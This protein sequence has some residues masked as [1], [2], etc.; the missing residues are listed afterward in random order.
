M[1]NLGNVQRGTRLLDLPD[2]I[3]IQIAK[4]SAPPDIY[5]LC[6]TSKHFHSATVGE[7]RKRQGDGK[8]SLASHLMHV[9]MKCNLTTVLAKNTGPGSFV[10]D[11]LSQFEPSSMILTGSTVACAALGGTF[12]C[13]DTDIFKTPGAAPAVRSM[14]VKEG[15]YVL[16][17][18]QYNYYYDS[19]SQVRSDEI[20]E[21][22]HICSTLHACDFIFHRPV[23]DLY[24]FTL[25][26]NY[27]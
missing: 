9:T 17:G 27:A 18:F 11:D 1:N 20:L 4:L 21:L 3:F 13:T 5:A 8:K 14:L 6:Q 23:S 10:P 19:T 2:E 7:K 12:D 24:L 25:Y 16:M 15:N 26:V 22:I